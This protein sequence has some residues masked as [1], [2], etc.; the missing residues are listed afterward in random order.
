MKQQF[1]TS[2]IKTNNKQNKSKLTFS[3]FWAFFSLIILIL[4]ASNLSLAQDDRKSI[5]VIPSQVNPTDHQISADDAD[6]SKLSSFADTS[7]VRSLSLQEIIDIALEHNR[8]LKT[9]RL[10]EQSAKIRLKQAEYRFLPSGYLSGSRNENTYVTLGQVEKTKKYVSSLGISRALETGGYVS[11]GLNNS[12]TESTA[13]LGIINYNSGLAIY[14]WQPLLAGRGLKVNKVP[15]ERA[16]DYARISLLRVKQNLIDLITAIE[17]QYWDLILVYEDLKIQQQALARANELL[18]INKSL[19]ES[20]RMAA[21][22]IVQTES[23][24]ASREISLAAAE[25]SIITTQIVLQAQLDLGERIL[26]Q[27]TTKL[28]FQPVQINIGDCLQRA[29]KNRPDWLIHNLY[30][31]IERMN[32][33]VAQNRK[34]YTLGSS[35][36]IGSDVTSD[37]GLE[38]SLRDA[39]MFKELAWNVGLSFT[40]PFNKQV[41]EN[42]YQLYK[43]SFER[44]QLYLQ[45]LKD[46]IRIAVETAVR[47]VQFTLKQV[48]LA[49]RAKELA[50]KKL[51]LEEDKM[52]VGR[53]SNFQVISYQ[54]DL[55]NAQNK[56]LRAIANYLKAIGQ[57]EA[58]MGTTLEKWGIVVEEME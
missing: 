41:L 23:D 7:N 1:F 39:L 47:N 3:R 29:F 36:S 5:A 8:I 17:S 25:N 22:E 35:A 49:Q 54:R 33:L 44:Q 45:E 19:I 55:T 32:L 30:L 50:K 16:K 20:G 12:T 13:N 18:E 42:S 48:G 37:H 58:T 21:Q 34:M 40:F 38:K 11:L 43:L 15:I 9:Y 6:L 46:N 53:S 56:E 52:K 57:L 10:R 31:D 27:P 24:I 14:I 2:I 51:T 26:I 4:S 28:E